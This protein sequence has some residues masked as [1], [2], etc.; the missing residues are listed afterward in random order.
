[1]KEVSRREG[2]IKGEIKGQVKVYYQ[3]LNYSVDQIAEELGMSVEAVK[4]IIR[5]L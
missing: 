5:T 2:E 1:M 3:K 4:E